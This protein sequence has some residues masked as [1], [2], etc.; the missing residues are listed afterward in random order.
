VIKV[1][2]MKSV[3]GWPRSVVAI[4]RDQQRVELLDSLSDATEFQ[5]IYVESIEGG[6]SRI[7]HVNPDLV[8]VAFAI[9]D[10]AA[11]RLLSMLKSDDSLAC[12][13][14]ITC[15]LPAAGV[16]LGLTGPS[17]PISQLAA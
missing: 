16:G 2:M 11:C 12:V 10:D 15:V 9:D 4:S 14:V 1:E 6:Y 7:K 3:S 8:I 13:P 17:L 5:T